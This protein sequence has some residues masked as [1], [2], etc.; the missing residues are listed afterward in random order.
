[1]AETGQQ[2]EVDVA[3]DARLTPPLHCDSADEART[4]TAL[5]AKGLKIA[6]RLEN[7]NHRRSFAKWRCISTNPVDSSGGW[8]RAA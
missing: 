6:G 2:R 5:V 7:R 8:V 1:M 4:P 3:R